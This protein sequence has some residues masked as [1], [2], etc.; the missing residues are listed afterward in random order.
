MNDLGG[1]FIQSVDRLFI[2]GRRIEELT[3]TEHSC[4]NWQLEKSQK[5]FDKLKNN[6]RKALEALEPGISCTGCLN[7]N[8]KIRLPKRWNG[9]ARVQNNKEVPKATPVGLT[10]CELLLIFKIKPKFNLSGILPWSNSNLISLGLK[11][12]LGYLCLRHSASLILL[13]GKTFNGRIWEAR[14]LRHIYMF[15]INGEFT[16]PFEKGKERTVSF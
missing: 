11:R 16:H 14:Y 13:L 6:E 5:D 3:L 4:K 8:D 10:Y 7:L 9:W 12:R 1:N 15:K 2:R